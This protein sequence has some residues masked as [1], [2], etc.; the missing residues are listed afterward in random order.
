M[1]ILILYASYSGGTMQ[2]AQTINDILAAK[3][4]TVTLKQVS[5]AKLEDIEKA[6]KL[7]AVDYVNKTFFD[8]DIIKITVNNPT[9][10]TTVIVIG[11][12]F[13]FVN[14]MAA[15]DSSIKL[16]ACLFKMANPASFNFLSCA[17]EYP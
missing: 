1:N 11:I 12:Q 10:P 7:G 17:N 6:K 16:V 13:F 4:S 3:G 14:A 8:F 15:F 9:N 5:E 2:A